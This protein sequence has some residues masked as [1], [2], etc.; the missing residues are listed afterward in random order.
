MIIKVTDG[1]GEEI[2]IKA[3]ALDIVMYLRGKDATEV[4]NY[5]SDIERALLITE[6]HRKCRRD[7]YASTNS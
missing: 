1:N 7:N 2:V 3:F 4:F 5:L 6:I